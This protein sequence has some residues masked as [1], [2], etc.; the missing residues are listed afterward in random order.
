MVPAFWSFSYD[1]GNIKFY[2]LENT[3]ITVWINKIKAYQG[4]LIN[5]IDDN[6][7]ILLVDN[8]IGTTIIVLSQ[9]SLRFEKVKNALY[10]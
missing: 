7:R 3:P 2:T 6:G 1:I 4:N 10:G 5:D 9:E 8:N